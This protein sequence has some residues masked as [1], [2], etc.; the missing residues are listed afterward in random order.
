MCASVYLCKV[1]NFLQGKLLQRLSQGMPIAWAC[2]LH[3]L[4]SV[5]AFPPA[6]L[7][8]FTELQAQQPACS[9]CCF[10]FISVCLFT[11]IWRTLPPTFPSW[12]H[13]DIS[14]KKSLL[15]RRMLRE[16]LPCLCSA[17]T[18]G[19][20][21][22]ILVTLELLVYESFPHPHNCKLLQAET[23]IYS[24]LSPQELNAEEV[25]KWMYEKW[26]NPTV[27]RGQSSHFDSLYWGS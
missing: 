1:F 2:A 16:A 19:R 14:F 9:P 10:C 15:G 23:L 27:S 20:P 18:L 12:C 26:V 13:S 8:A 7:Q 22:C 17:W 21:Q 5:P 25:L 24:F 6:T 3:R 4:S 11:F